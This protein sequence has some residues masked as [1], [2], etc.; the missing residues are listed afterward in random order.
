MLWM[1]MTALW[2]VM[3]VAPLALLA[4]LLPAGRGCPRC[5]TETFLLQSRALRPVQRLFARRWCS[6][7][8]WE[9]LV[10]TTRPGAPAPASPAPAT[11]EE[12]DDDAVWR[13]EQR[14]G[15]TF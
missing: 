14:D 7:C 15:N 1:V 5:G 13:G 12:I 8:G 9:G 3:L 11:G 4:A 6:G 2:I 10:R